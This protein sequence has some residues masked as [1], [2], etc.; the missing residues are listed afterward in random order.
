M[1]GGRSV[2]VDGGKPQEALLS[3]AAAAGAHNRV[4]QGCSGTNQVVW[5]P[6]RK[7]AAPSSPL[8]E[9][10]KRARQ[11]TERQ[12]GSETPPERCI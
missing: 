8:P 3:T 11:S 4:E 12:H 9:L 1:Q 6:S 5:H 2:Q 10:T 7:T